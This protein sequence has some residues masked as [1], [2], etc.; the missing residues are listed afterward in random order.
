EDNLDDIEITK[1]ALKQAKVINNLYIVRDGQ[2][3][4]DFLFHQG[5]YGDASC[6]PRPGLILLDIN[7]PRLNGIEVLIRL[8]KDEALKHIPVIML[9]VSKRDEDIVRS[10]DNGCNSF[11]Q[12]PVDF[13]KFVDV[14]KELALYWGLLNIPCPEVDIEFKCE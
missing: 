7:M 6:A 9:T 10:Y 11:I 14:I 1:R 4:I 8:K 12:K 2:E 13:N 3:A 5:D